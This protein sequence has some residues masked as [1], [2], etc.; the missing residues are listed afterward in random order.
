MPCRCAGVNLNK[1]KC[2]IF[3]YPVKKY[4][5]SNV[6]LL[7][8]SESFCCSRNSTGV[9]RNMFVRIAECVYEKCAGYNLRYCQFRGFV[10]PDNCLANAMKDVFVLICFLVANFVVLLAI[11]AKIA[12]HIYFFV[13]ETSHRVKSE[14]FSTSFSKLVKKLTC[15]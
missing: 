2:K 9:Q 13:S 14:Y 15:Q 5:D 6:V 10:K 3:G 7:T 4:D 1:C 11:L 8:N 12:C